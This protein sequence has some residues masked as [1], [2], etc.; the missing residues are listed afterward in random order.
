MP[1][2]YFFLIWLPCENNPH[3]KKLSDIVLK[4]LKVKCINIIFWPSFS[5]IKSILIVLNLHDLIKNEQQWLY[6][7]C[8]KLGKILNFL[9]RCEYNMK[10]MSPAPPPQPSPFSFRWRIEFKR[11]YFSKHENCKMKYTEFTDIIN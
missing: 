10:V 6:L 8:I 11:I 9:G 2:K 4:K 3:E 1:H 5:P 7:H